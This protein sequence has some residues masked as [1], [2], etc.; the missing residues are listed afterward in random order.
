[1]ASGRSNNSWLIKVEHDWGLI[2]EAVLKLIRS[3]ATQYGNLE[4]WGNPYYN[5]KN[6]TL[7]S[8]YIDSISDIV[9]LGY[10]YVGLPQQPCFPHCERGS[11]FTLIVQL[12]S[13][14]TW[15]SSLSYYQNLLPRD[16][17]IGNYLWDFLICT[18]KKIYN[19][20]LEPKNYVAHS[21]LL[22]LGMSN[23]W[24]DKKYN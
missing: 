13:K 4:P 5:M 9:W 19:F 6:V 8:I 14:S 7:M 18:E 11:F 12:I 2:R 10:H 15:N 17:S 24:N 3:S 1:M 22:E 23:E 16:L 21:W 20:L